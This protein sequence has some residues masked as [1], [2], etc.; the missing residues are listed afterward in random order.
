MVEFIRQYVT[1]AVGLL[2]VLSAIYFVFWVLLGK[3]LAHRKIQLS[4]RAGWLQIKEEIITSLISFIGSTCFVFIILNLK[5][6]GFV[7]FYTETG[8]YGIWYEVVT[9]AVLL[10]VSDAWF[11]WSHRIMH[12]PKIY[13]YVH[14]LHHKSL[15]VNPYTSTSFHIIESVWLTAWIL[16]LVMLMPVS[17]TA[18]GAMQA[19]GTFNNIKSHLGYEF[20]PQF[21]KLPPFNMLVTATNHSLH[22]TQYNGNYGLFFRFW[23]ILCGTELTTTTATFTEIH[24]RKHEHIIDNTRY[25]KLVIDKLVKENNETIS[26][27]FKPN[28]VQFYKYLAGQH[29]TL[30][31]NVNGKKHHRCFSLSSSPNIDK[32]LRITV[33]LK[34][35]VSHY[36]YNEAK[37]GDTIEALYPVGDFTFVPNSGVIKNYVF[38]AGGSGI[39]PLY[40]MLQQILH[41]EPNSKVHLFYANKNEQSIIFKDEIQQLAA[42]YPKFKSQYFISGKNRITKNDISNF[43]DATYFICGPSSLQQTMVTYLKDLKIDTSKV[44]TAYFADGYVPWFGLFIKKY[45]V[46]KLAKQAAALS[47]ALFFSFSAASQTEIEGKWHDVDH[48]EKIVTIV[49]NN[50][51]FSGTDATGKVVF[52]DVTFVSKK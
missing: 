34:G 25:K 31:V 15:D 51:M 18:L 38:V 49:A 23:D 46:P 32:F 14:A 16:P 45:S 37:V 19:L 40:S 7:K 41:F 43:N 12:H 10:L 24:N 5:D 11:Y 50:K 30:L 35:E 20:Y 29:L 33:K 8:K 17:M 2:V 13:K 27:Y 28:D 36:F 22:H 6:K 26:V 47:I 52:K 1:S 44:N 48:S 39:T 3:K 42:Q 9:V 21:F 4:K